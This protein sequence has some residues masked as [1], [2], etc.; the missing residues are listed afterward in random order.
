ML[1]WK[2]MPSITLMMSTMRVAEV[3]MAS[4]VCTTL[5]TTAPPLPATSAAEITISLACRALTAFW[6]TVAVSSSIEAAVCSSELACD[7]VRADRSTLPLAISEEARAMVSALRRI[8]PMVLANWVC[9]LFMPK[10]M[11][12]SSRAST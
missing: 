10:K 4:M 9:M 6:L 12:L 2:A 8:S 3:L 7:S 5:A 1:V 11:L